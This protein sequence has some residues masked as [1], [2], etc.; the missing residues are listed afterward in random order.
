MSPKNTATKNRPVALG[1]YAAVI[2]IDWADQKHAL[3]TFCAP[4]QGANAPEHS[5]LAQKSEAAHRMDQRASGALR[6]PGQPGRDSR[7]TQRRAHPFS[8]RL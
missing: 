8:E 3:A 7:T 5:E 2:G 6:R 4:F 1:D